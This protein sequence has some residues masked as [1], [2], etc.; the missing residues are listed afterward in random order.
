MIIPK[1]IHRKMTARTLKGAMIKSLPILT[2]EE[3]EDKERQAS[4]NTTDFHQRERRI[5]QKGVRL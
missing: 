3:R 5:I 4:F 1:K 2:T